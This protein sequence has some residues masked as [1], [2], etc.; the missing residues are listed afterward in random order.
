MSHGISG[1]KQNM[2]SYDAS[3]LTHHPPGKRS[4][5]YSTC[6][7]GLWRE[8]HCSFYSD[9][10]ACL[11]QN[12]LTP[13]RQARTNTSVLRRANN[14]LLYCST[15]CDAQPLDHAVALHQ[16]ANHA[17]RQSRA[18]ILCAVCVRAALNAPS[19]FRV[20]AQRC[21]LPLPGWTS[22]NKPT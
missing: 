15:A 4:S 17:A 20:H 7:L 11:Y 14:V 19:I 22:G 1:R 6:R 2:S 8:H 18:S 5:L 13:T 9:T 16:G 3:C 21:D 12:V 10:Y